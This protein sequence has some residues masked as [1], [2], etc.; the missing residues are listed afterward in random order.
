LDQIELVLL[1]LFQLPHFAVSVD[2]LN[3]LIVEIKL[4][5]FMH[6]FG[7]SEG[8]EH[9]LI[10]MVVILKLVDFPLEFADL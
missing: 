6:V 7:W 9:H 2:E 5:K 1:E 8:F 4:P 3:C 10:A